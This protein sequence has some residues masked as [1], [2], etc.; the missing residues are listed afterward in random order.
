[1]MYKAISDYKEGGDSFRFVGLG[2]SRGLYDVIGG[3]GKVGDKWKSRLRGRRSSLPHHTLGRLPPSLALARS[4]R[5]PAVV[6]RL[7]RS[8]LARPAPLPFP[9]PPP[10]QP[11]VLISL[12]QAE[13]ALR[14]ERASERAIVVLVPLPPRPARVLS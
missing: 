6:G 9:L 7:G 2:F 8:V 13:S 1:M 10:P 11:R 4:L 14:S 12:S 3:K 5:P